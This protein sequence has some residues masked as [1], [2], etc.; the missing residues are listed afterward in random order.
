MTDNAGQ[1]CNKFAFSTPHRLTSCNVKS[2]SLDVLLVYYFECIHTFLFIY[3]Y[4]QP[5]PVAIWKRSLMVLLRHCL[6]IARK[7]RPN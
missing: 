5:G 1:G 6:L 2:V 3:H 4:L 7:V